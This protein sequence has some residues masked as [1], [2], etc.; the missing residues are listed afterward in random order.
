MKKAIFL[1]RD[2]TIN[3][4][5]DYIYK[6]ED[7]EF[8]VGVIEALK[9]FKKLGYM[10]IVVTNQSGI[11]RNYYTEED[12]KNFNDHMNNILKEYNADIDAFYFCP[13]HPTKAIGEYKKDCS[14]RKP[15]NKMIEDAIKE[16][17]I[18]RENSYMIGDKLSDIQAGIKSNLQTVIVKTGYG[19]EE[20]KK[21][22]NKTIICDKLIDFSNLLKRTKLK[23]LIIKEFKKDV[24][25]SSV[26]MDSRKIE[27]NSLFFAINNGNKFIKE[28]LEK[29]ASIVIADK[30]DIIDDR[31]ILVNNTIETMQ[32]LATKYRKF[33]NLTVIGITGSNGKTTTKDIVHSILSREYPTLKT[34]GNYNNHIGLPFTLL[35]LTDEHK[36]AVLEMGM[37]N[38]GEIKRLA[39][40]SNPDY[41]IITN[42]GESHLEYLGSREGVFKAKTE[43]LD[44]V[45]KNN[46]FVCGDDSF[47]NNLDVIKVGFLEKNN[48]KIENFSLNNSTSYFTFN[49]KNYST[50]L[51]GKHNVLNSA[52]AIALAERLNI[53]QEEIKKGIENIQISKMRFQEV[54]IN[55]DIYINDAYNASPTSMKASIDTFNSIYNDRYKIAVLGDILEIGENEIDFHIEVLNYLLDKNIKLIYL[56]GERMKK[57]LEIFL[58][59]KSEEYRFWHYDKKE[60]I[61]ASLE[62]IK[63]KKI[64]LL[65]ASRGMRLEEIIEYKKEKIE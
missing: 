52:L 5:K 11:G 22:D 61:F 41:A 64:V 34:E 15:N 31:V 17:N 57:A 42:I 29:G 26:V 19:K 18:D 36:F 4:D 37:S 51:L 33:L 63:M 9:N 21:V 40:I 39:E 25:I 62:K 23:E 7:L 48:L 16:Y 58:N 32:N 49:K 13:H 45:D 8:E 27:K 47:L 28:A 50:N 14:C 55:E 44:F 54:I 30:T 6:K 20:F 24:N 43:I 56:Y 12:L 38:F 35:N 3:V 65:K 60:D 1:D 59:N 46:V 53:K 10:L 2:G